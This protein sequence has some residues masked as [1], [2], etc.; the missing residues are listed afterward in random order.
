[1]QVVLLCSIQI[2]APSVMYIFG[3][4]NT[5]SAHGGRGSVFVDDNKDMSLLHPMMSL[6]HYRSTVL[7]PCAHW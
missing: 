7:D 5:P 2:N 3:Q 6:H 4:K 1:M